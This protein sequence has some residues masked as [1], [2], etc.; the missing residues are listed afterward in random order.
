MTIFKYSSPLIVSFDPAAEMAD[1]DDLR[2]RIPVGATPVQGEVT[3][4]ADPDRV[5]FAQRSPLCAAAGKPVK[6]LT[7]LASFSF[8]PP[9]S[10]AI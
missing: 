4:P 9:E 5:G 2:S 10:A 8:S 1:P 3:V 7:Q 6:E